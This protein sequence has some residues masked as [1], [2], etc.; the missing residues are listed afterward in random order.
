MA[1]VAFLRKEPD[2]A[3]TDAEDH[4]FAKGESPLLG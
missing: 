4:G 3:R 1:E 2:Y